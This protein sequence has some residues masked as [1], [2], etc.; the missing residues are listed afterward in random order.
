MHIQLDF[1]IGTKIRFLGTVEK[2]GVVAGYYFSNNGIYV[3][4]KD[5]E[6]YYAYTESYIRDRSLVQIICKGS[7]RV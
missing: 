3:K 5:S 2:I 4:F 6:Y 1:P 7:G